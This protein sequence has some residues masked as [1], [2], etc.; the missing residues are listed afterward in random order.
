MM[1]YE[2]DTLE[3]LDVWISEESVEIGRD[4]LKK[5]DRITVF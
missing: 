3:E 1:R 5:G 4:Q 2:T